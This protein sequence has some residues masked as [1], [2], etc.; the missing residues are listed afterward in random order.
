MSSNGRLIGHCGAAGR[1]TARAAPGTELG[2]A[3]A[4]SLIMFFRY[5]LQTN[6]LIQIKLELV[7]VLKEQ[8]R[9]LETAS[10]SV[11]SMERYK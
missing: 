10:K 9:M 11:A 7:L 1:D 6:P 8:R 3:G 4:I 5:D 2:D